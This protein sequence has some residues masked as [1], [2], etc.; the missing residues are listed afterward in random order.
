M[1]SSRP[2]PTTSDR[3]EEVQPAAFLAKRSKRPVALNFE[4]APP[5]WRLPEGWTI[6]EQ[7]RGSGKLAG[8]AIDKAYRSPEGKMCRSKMEV[9]RVVEADRQRRLQ[10]LEFQREQELQR[11]QQQQ[12]QQ[13]QQEQQ[14]QSGES[15]RQLVAVQPDALVAVTVPPAPIGPVLVPANEA[16]S[17]ELC[18]KDFKWTSNLRRHTLAVHLK[19]KPFECPQRNCPQTFATKSNAMRHYAA[20]HAAEAAEALEQAA[21]RVAAAVTTQP[22]KSQRSAA[23]ASRSGA[24]Y[25]AAIRD[26]SDAAVADGGK[27]QPLSVREIDLEDAAD[28]MPLA[29]DKRKS[30]ASSP[31]VV[32]TASRKRTGDELAGDAPGDAAELAKARKL[33]A[34]RKTPLDPKTEFRG[35]CAAPG[36]KVATDGAE[37]ARCKVFEA[38]PRNHQQCRWCGH[39]AKDHLIESILAF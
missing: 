1:R 18:G 5:N 23:R 8:I 4:K 28:W 13:E 39:G 11:Q 22:K 29:G 12:E 36:C 27:R 17:C 9:T 32:R 16:F 10:Q 26:T 15:E 25:L 35:K 24:S 34:E 33:N 37:P 14:N 30:D 21:A 3:N 2:R 38:E 20:H 31:A 7:V 19:E 6:I